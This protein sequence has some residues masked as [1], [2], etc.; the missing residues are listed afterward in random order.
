VLDELRRARVLGGVA[1]RLLHQ[2]EGRAGEARVF[3]LLRDL[4]DAG[5]RRTP[6]EFGGHGSS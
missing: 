5:D 2:G 4:G 3:D 1:D 6:V